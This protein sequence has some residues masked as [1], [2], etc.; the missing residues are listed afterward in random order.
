MATFERKG[1]KIRVRIRRADVAPMSR[2]FDRRKDAERWARETEVAIDKGAHTEA[3][4][5]PS[6]TITLGELLEVYSEYECP[7]HRGEAQEQSQI[8]TWLKDADKGGH[9]LRDFLLGE[10]RVVDVQRWVEALNRSG[11]RPGTVKK[12]VGLV[13]RAVN[14][15]RTEL[16]GFTDLPYNPFSTTAGLELP[17]EDEE[18]ERSRILS[19]Q[20]ASLL[21]RS[22]DPEATLPDGLR[23]PRT[24]W[25]LHAFE[26]CLDVGLRASE[27]LSLRWEDIDWTEHVARIRRTKSR[28]SRS[29]PLPPASLNALH[30]MAP[31]AEGFGPVFNGHDY[32]ALKTAWRRAVQRARAIYELEC[33]AEGLKPSPHVLADLRLHD[34]RHHAITRLMGDGLDIRQTMAVSGH[35]D[36]RMLMRYTHPIAADIARDL[37][38]VRGDQLT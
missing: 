18:S 3:P 27:T 32:Q 13:A 22:L 37:H 38:R 17:K 35:A 29:V 16:W 2:T 20:E 15:A 8:R 9:P 1:K 5:S 4:Q 21:R 28:R 31:P 7:K 19:R 6:Y 10:I 11:R 14:K 23:P 36:M 33:K 30:A 12:Q 26:I 24:A 25:P 34:L